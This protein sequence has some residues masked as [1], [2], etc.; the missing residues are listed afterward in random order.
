MDEDA[1]WVAKAQM[2]AAVGFID[3]PESGAFLTLSAED[4]DHLLAID[5]LFR[6]MGNITH[7]VLDP[8]RNSPEP[9]ADHGH[10]QAD[11]RHQQQHRQGQTPGLDQHHADQG[12]N[13]KD[14]PE[15]SDQRRGRGLGDLLGVVGHARNHLARRLPIEMAGRQA[16]IAIEQFL[17]QV[18]N[19]ATTDPFHAEYATEVSDDPDQHGNHH[20]PR[21]PPAEGGI[22]IDD[23]VV[24]QR[25]QQIEEQALPEGVQSYSDD[26]QA[27]DQSLASEIGQQPAEGAAAGARAHGAV[28]DSSTAAMVRRSTPS[29]AAASM[30]RTT[31]RWAASASARMTRVASGWA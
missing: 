26:G 14:V 3:R 13:G 6:D 12:D 15:R 19:Q 29:A 27:E 4:L 22:R 1:S 31:S 9:T 16:E 25:A 5:R 21:Q 23:G 7:G 24:D 8:G 2:Q 30:T 20:Q 10:D 18:G 17:A 11:D 28:P